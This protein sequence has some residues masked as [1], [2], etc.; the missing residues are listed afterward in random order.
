MSQKNKKRNEKHHFKCRMALRFDT[1][2]NEEYYSIKNQIL[3]GSSKFIERQSKRTSIHAVMFKNRYIIVVY[4]NF[5]Q[6]LVTVLPPEDKFYKLF[7]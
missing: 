7:N 5:R 3:I 4:D 2:N 6:E 1:I